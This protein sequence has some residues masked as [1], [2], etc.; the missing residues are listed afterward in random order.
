M[1]PRR[2]K[3]VLA[4]VLN[5]YEWSYLVHTMNRE[6]KNVSRSDNKDPKNYGDRE[7]FRQIMNGQ[8]FGYQV[9]VSRTTGR[10]ALGISAPIFAAE[11]RDLVGVISLAA[12]L[13]DISE[14]VADVKIGNSG[15]AMLLDKNGKVIAHG[16]PEKLSETLQDLGDHPAFQEEAIGKQII[17]E[18]DGRQIVAYSQQTDNKWTLIVQQDYDDAFAPLLQAKRNSTILLIVS[19]SAAFFVALTF[20]WRLVKPLESLTRVADGFSR[21]GLDEKI[22][23]TNRGDEIGAL[24]RAIERMGVSIKMAFNELK[25]A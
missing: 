1:D 11:S 6:G 4:T 7:Y 17:Y 23:E 19:L 2:Q 18:E 10:P 16:S 3:P 12:H 14:A 13:V 8:P 20:A 15:F 22:P 5:T 24:A 21:G 25:A 9:I